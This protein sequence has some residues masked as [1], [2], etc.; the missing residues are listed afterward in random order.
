MSVV[1]IDRL[2]AKP[3]PDP[4]RR[5]LGLVLSHLER[6]ACDKVT[7]SIKFTFEC[8]DGNILEQ[9]WEARIKDK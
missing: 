4:I 2:G 1:Q 6:A 5:A 7:G 3:K 8:K 9:W